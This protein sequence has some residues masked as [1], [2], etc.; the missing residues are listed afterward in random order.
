MVKLST[1]VI[2]IGVV[3]LFFPI[4]PVL[5]AIVGVAIIILGVAL[6]FVGDEGE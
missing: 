2:L 4:P 6:R 5:S 3:I 1:W